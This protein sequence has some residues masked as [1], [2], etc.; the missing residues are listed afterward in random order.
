MTD[1][2]ARLSSPHEHIFLGD[3]HQRNERRTWIVIAIT[4]TMMVAE[5]FSIVLSG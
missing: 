4:A 3:N 1:H 5:A 2:A